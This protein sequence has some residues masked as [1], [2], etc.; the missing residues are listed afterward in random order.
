MLLFSQ[1]APK[2]SWQAGAK[3]EQLQWPE[4]ASTPAKHLPGPTALQ[5]QGPALQP[6]CCTWQ[7]F[8]MQFQ[9]LT[10]WGWR[11]YYIMPENVL[12][13]WQKIARLNGNPASSLL[14]QTQAH[15]DRAVFISFA[16]LTVEAVTSTLC[17]ESAQKK[18]ECSGFIFYNISIS[19]PLTI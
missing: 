8:W 18:Q 15:N 6:P 14:E 11:K 2:L 3:S 5:T 9:I 16:V 7:V 4:G 12:D 1:E 17:S 10:G 13:C 19:L